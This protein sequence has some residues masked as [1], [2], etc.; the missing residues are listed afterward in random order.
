MEIFLGH[1]CFQQFIND[2]AQELAAFSD[3]IIRD[4][5]ISAQN[6]VYRSFLG[7]PV[8]HGFVVP[9]LL[10]TL[11]RCCKLRPESLW[12]VVYLAK[13]EACCAR[14]T[15]EMVL[16]NHQTAKEKAIATL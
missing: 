4:M 10:N 1:G 14:L 9:A 6:A 12:L 13:P 16:V 15:C 3:V 7:V 8:S 5:P 2:L 11:W